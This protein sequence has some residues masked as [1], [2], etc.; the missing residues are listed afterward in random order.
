[1]TEVLKDIKCEDCHEDIEVSWRVYAIYRD[2]GVYLCK[3]C[4]HDRNYKRQFCSR[5]G[6]NRGPTYLNCVICDAI[7]KEALTRN[8]VIKNMIQNLNNLYELSKK[9]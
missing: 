6:Y 4:L 8:D 3:K 9:N 7:V 5:C 2:H 1:M